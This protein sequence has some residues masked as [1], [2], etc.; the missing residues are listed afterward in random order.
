VE[1]KAERVNPV[2]VTINNKKPSCR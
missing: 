2:H 1:L